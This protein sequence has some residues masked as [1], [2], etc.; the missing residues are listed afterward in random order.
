MISVSG[1]SHM[2]PGA[3]TGFLDVSFDVPA[4][5]TAALVGDNGADNLDI[6]SSQALE[7]A[8]E[9]FRGAV[10]A[11][12]HDRA[13]LRTLGRF[14]HLDADGHLHEIADADAAIA[15]LLDG[16]GALSP[17]SRRRVTA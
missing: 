7:T 16:L 13:F 15:S 6:A 1:L 3:A 11:V 12:S 4:G 10:V 9:G 2:H 8:L 17:A 5:T 14:L